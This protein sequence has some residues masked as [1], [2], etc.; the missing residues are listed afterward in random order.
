MHIVPKTRSAIQKE[1]DRVLEDYTGACLDNLEERTEIARAIAVR[2][3]AYDTDNRAGTIQYLQ[4]QFGGPWGEYP[5]YPKCDWQ[6]EAAAND[7]SLGYW[8]WLLNK[9]KDD[10]FYRGYHTRV[11][12]NED[13]AKVMFG[14]DF[15]EQCECCGM[16]TMSNA[17][18]NQGSIVGPWVDENGHNK[19]DRVC[20]A[21]EQL[22]EDVA[23]EI[24]AKVFG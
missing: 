13:L 1:V 3:F 17:D 22:T 10:R 5:A 15:P 8:D 4:E 12:P 6:D 14:T 21:C 2:L 23:D 11:Y 20:I 18:V 19:F 24:H 7:T 16:W 9:L